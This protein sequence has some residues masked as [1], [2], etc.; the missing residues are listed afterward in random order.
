M[1]GLFGVLVGAG[2]WVVGAMVA[3]LAAGLWGWVI[4]DILRHEPTDGWSKLGWAY[5][6]LLT[7]PWGALVYVF[8]RRPHRLREYGE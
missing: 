6:V 8:A 5:G 1:T 3:V 2:L 7:P 4:A